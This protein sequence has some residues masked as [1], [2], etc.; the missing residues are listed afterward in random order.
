[1]PHQLLGTWPILWVL[2]QASLNK[3]LELLGEVAGQL[4]RVVL[5]D[6]EE[7]P[8]RVK[9]RVWRFALQINRYSDNLR[10]QR[11]KRGH[12]LSF[13]FD[14]SCFENLCEFNGC[15][16]EAPDISLG[17]ICRLLDHL[18]YKNV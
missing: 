15:D 14:W 6:E 10:W 2:V 16:P 3:L 17:V 8:H 5:G 1:M 12:R 7:N 13:N 9:V 4:G 18:G 11:R